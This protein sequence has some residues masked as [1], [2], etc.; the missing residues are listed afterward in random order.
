M[1][2]RVKALNNKKTIQGSNY[3]TAKKM[4]VMFLATQSSE[5]HH[6]LKQFSKNN[7][8]LMNFVC[9]FEYPQRA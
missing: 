7:G 4:K 2:K 3:W 9:Q 8:G 5:C 1:G 6:T